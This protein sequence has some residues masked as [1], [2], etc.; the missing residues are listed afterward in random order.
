MCV[1]VCVCMRIRE[2]MAGAGGSC[3]AHA[4]QSWD[5]LRRGAGASLS[6]GDIAAMY[7]A[8]PQP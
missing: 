1:C 8:R 7:E 4:V 6:T 3:S 5:G 2:G